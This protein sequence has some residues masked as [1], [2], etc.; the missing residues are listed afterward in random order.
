M[1]AR[2]CRGAWNRYL[3]DPTK[4]SPCLWSLHSGREELREQEQ[5]ASHALHEVGAEVSRGRGL[6]VGSSHSADPGL[7][8]QTLQW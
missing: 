3:G 7:P 1:H 4:H 8:G 6:G 5:D 2:H